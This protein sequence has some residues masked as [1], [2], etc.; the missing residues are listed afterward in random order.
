[1]EP[2]VGE[3]AAVVQVIQL[4]LA[5]AVMINACGLLLL[6]T[7]NK[8][9]TVLNRI[10]LLNDERRKLV[11]RA[12]EKTFEEMGRLESLSRQVDRLLLRG[13]FVRNTVLCYSAAIGLFL[14]TSLL[15]A[16]GYFAESFNSPA[17]VMVL[18]LL[19]MTL[20]LCGVGFS[21]LDTKR[22]YDIVVYDVK[23]DE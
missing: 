18:F 6:A 7:S 2:R 19:G 1:M 5:P 9:S 10:R 15:M 14:M 12:G 16:L 21:F 8:Y 13:R 3:Y 20:V 11:R 4:I 23:V 22:G 17:A